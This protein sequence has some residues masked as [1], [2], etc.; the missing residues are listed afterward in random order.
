V[1]VSEC[2]FVC[3]CVPRV[4]DDLRVFRFV[5]AVTLSH[6]L[7]HSHTLSHTLTHSHTLMTGL[8]YGGETCLAAKG[9]NSTQMISYES[10]TLCLGRR[11]QEGVGPYTSERVVKDFLEGPS[12][13]DLL[14]QLVYARARAHTDTRYTHPPTHTHT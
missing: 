8:A 6:T 4:S 5:Q 12:N 14:Y 1:R 2:V 13:Y 11:I 9:L 7:T 10:A 3:V